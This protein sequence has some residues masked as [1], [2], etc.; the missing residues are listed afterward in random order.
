M[1]NYYVNIY[2]YICTYIK[3]AITGSR[4]SILN[5]AC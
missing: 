4:I 2:V 5:G 3:R 1:G